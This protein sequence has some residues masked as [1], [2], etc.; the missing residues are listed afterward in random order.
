VAPD[1]RCAKRH[2]L[3]IEEAA[4]AV[5]EFLREFTARVYDA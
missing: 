5:S 1:I 2:F 3:I 4:E